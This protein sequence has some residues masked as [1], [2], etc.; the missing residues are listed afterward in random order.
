MIQPWLSRYA[1]LMR[2]LG[3]A[4]DEVDFGGLEEARCNALRIALRRA[5]ALEPAP[6][7]QLDEV[8]RPAFEELDAALEAC[9]SGNEDLWAIQL[10]QA[11]ESTHATQV[12]MDERYGYGGVLELE[13]ESAIGVDRSRESISG[14]FLEKEKEAELGF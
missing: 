6:D 10:L 13:L 9:L 8:L 14:R 5:R 12:L 7:P 3:S 1:D 4:L 2:P 11:K